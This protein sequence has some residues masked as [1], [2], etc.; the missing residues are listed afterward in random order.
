[1][2]HSRAFKAFATAA[3]VFACA[4]S[5]GQRSW[6]K[7]WPS[8][9]WHEGKVV[10]VEGDTLKGLVKY[11]FQ[12][13]LVQY[14]VSNN[15]A[16]I[17][18]ARKVLFFEI[19]DETVHRYRKFFALPYGNPSGYKAPMFF[20][21]LE[22]GKMTLLARELLEYRTYN[23]AFYAGSYSR[24]VQTDYFYLLRSDGTIEDFRG[25]KNDLLN[26]MGNKEKAVEKYIRDNRLNFDDKYDVAKIVAYYNSLM[27]S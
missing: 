17:L 4:F 11:D 20:E 3:F 5:F 7:T 22:E 1:M 26:K 23:N 14:I 12:Q 21:L 27:G 9:L 8:E 16:I 2:P 18:H 10:L 19:F 6:Q 15:K 24:L 25:N 13:N